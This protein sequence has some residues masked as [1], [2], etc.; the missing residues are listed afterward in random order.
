MKIDL[1]F[2][3][4]HSNL[5]VDGMNF[6]LKLYADPKKNK[7][8]IKIWYDTDLRHTAVLY[9][10]KISLIESTASMTLKDPNQIGY[11]SEDLEVRHTVV[12]AGPVIIP[13]IIKAQVSTPQDKVQGKPGRKAKYQ[14]EESQGE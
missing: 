12:N 6:G 13:T 1:E 7:A 2:V 4:L 3:E 14:G 11:N 10:D 8:P 5:F 9:K